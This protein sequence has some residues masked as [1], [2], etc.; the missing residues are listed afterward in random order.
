MKF[1]L[2]FI[3]NVHSCYF[4]FNEMMIHLCDLIDR[5]RNS[6]YMVQLAMQLSAGFPDKGVKI[7][8]DGEIIEFIKEDTDPIDK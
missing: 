2:F 4:T 1:E 5:E 8:S 7:K 3:G 6:P